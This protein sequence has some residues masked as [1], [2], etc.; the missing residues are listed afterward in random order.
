MK[1][2]FLTLFLGFHQWCCSAGE[3]SVCENKSICLSG[4]TAN[5]QPRQSQLFSP[6]PKKGP[7][8]ICFIEENSVCTH[9]YNKGCRKKKE[10]YQRRS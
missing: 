1:G 7:L 9:S 2:K 3:E 5:P 10:K 8:N 6:V 4:A